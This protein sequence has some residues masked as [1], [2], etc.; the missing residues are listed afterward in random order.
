MSRPLNRIAPRYSFEL[1]IRI[2]LQHGDQTRVVGGWARDISET[3]VGA[4]VAEEL[5]V[6][7]HVILEIPLAKNV[8]LTVPAKVAR[9]LGTEVPAKVARSLG[10]EYGFT[11]TA[12]SAEQRA[13]ILS[14]V[15]GKV[16]I[17]LPRFNA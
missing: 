4:F 2:R 3:G 7:E 11:F 9:S 5:E 14:A 17:A 8:K 16:A 13:H 15:Q 12:L 1:R 10:T 6:G